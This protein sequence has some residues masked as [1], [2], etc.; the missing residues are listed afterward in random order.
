MNVVGQEGNDGNR[1]GSGGIK[2]P[3]NNVLI[4]LTRVW[5]QDHGDGDHYDSI[6]VDYFS[7]EPVGEIAAEGSRDEFDDDIEGDDEGVFEVFDGLGLV[8]VEL[9]LQEHRL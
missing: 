6:Q 4:K 5:H 9:L 1:D 3:Q 2:A 7:A 8:D